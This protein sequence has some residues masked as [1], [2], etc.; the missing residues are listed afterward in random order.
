MPFEPRTWLEID[1]HCFEHNLAQVRSRARSA[2]IMSVI[3]ANAYGHGIALAAKGLASS[4]EF[5]VTDLNE[6]CTLRELGVG[7]AITTL[8]AYYD[9]TDLDYAASENIQLTVYDASQIE[10]IEN[11]K[12]SKPLSI[13]LK[14]DTGMGRLGFNENEVA[15]V[16]ARLNA[17]EQVHSIGLLSHLANADDPSNAYNQLQF[18]SLKRVSDRFK[19][20]RRS[21]LNSAGLCHTSPLIYDVV[22]PGIMLYGAS[23]LLGKT[24]Q[25]LDLAPV[26]TLK[27][28]VLSVKQIK[29]GAKIGYGSDYVCKSDTEVAIIACG[30]GDGYPRRVAGARVVINDQVCPVLGRPSMD[31]ITVDTIGSNAAVGDTAIIW[32]KHNPIEET[33]LAANTISYELMTGITNRVERRV[34]N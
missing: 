18:M 33:A 19:W 24:S 4:D 20:Q 30:Y 6:A 15:S 8:S 32:G 28:R 10:L 9:K 13:W 2:S 16:F 3:K 7:Q 29:A 26:M 1:L 21:L 34:I 14:V 11:T 17:L 27:A 25:D 23:P 22:R 31:M 5:A 12:L